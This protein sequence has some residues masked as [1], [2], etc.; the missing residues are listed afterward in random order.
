MTLVPFVLL[1]ETI[2]KAF[3]KAGMPQDRA[4]TCAQIHTESTCDGVNSHGINRVERFIEYIHEGLV[5]VHASPTRETSLGAIE[6]YNGQMGPGVLNAI[7]AMDR[8]TEIAGQHGIGLVSLK[9][10][11]HWMRGGAYG[12]QAADKGFMAIC[13]TNTESCMPPWGATSEAVGNNPF[14][15]AVPRAEGHI[16]LDMAMSQFSWGRI[17]GMRDKQQ[18]LPFAGGFDHEGNISTDA[19]AISETRRIL[20]M[21]M[22]KGSG[23]AIMLD[24]FAALLAN[25]LATDGV[26]KLNRGSAGGSSQVFIAID[27]LKMNSQAF[28]DA[29]LQDTIAHLKAAH[30]ADEQG[31]IFYPGEQSL[32]TRKKNLE[33]GI[34]VD[35]NVW[36]KVQE[37]A[38]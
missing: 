31:E 32:R 33:H 20:P 10:T 28:I 7:F 13:W 29:T 30:R 36:K 23:F 34:P 24:L 18:P 5:D 8:A 2:K 38:S 27:P 21:G 22:W 14:V 37:L 19:A 16:V 25:G 15:M 11:T 26:D 1:K 35:D 17:W 3:L 4:E 9:N 12:W 6:I